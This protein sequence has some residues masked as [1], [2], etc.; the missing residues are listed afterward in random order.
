M[1]LLE[2]KKL[3]VVEVLFLSFEKIISSKGVYINLNRNVTLNDY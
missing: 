3:K 2:Q 1:K